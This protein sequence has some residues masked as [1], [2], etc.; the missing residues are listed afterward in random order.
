MIIAKSKV[1]FDEREKKANKDVMFWICHLDD[2]T[3]MMTLGDNYRTA[4]CMF[5]ALVTVAM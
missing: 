3:W 4:T 1:I 5:Y 2:V